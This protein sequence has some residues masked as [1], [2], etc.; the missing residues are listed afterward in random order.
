M[1]TK[2]EKRKQR[3]MTTSFFMSYRLFSVSPL[4]IVV[5]VAHFYL[6][7]FH[8]YLSVVLALWPHMNFSLSLVCV[9]FFF[10]SLLSPSLLSYCCRPFHCHI[11]LLFVEFIFSS[12]RIRFC[13]PRRSPEEKKS[14]NANYRMESYNERHL[15]CL[16]ETSQHTR[17]V[18]VKK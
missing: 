18:D 9:C 16:N 6:K 14:L 15:I 1:E 5:V 8:I 11:L 7:Y 2:R 12:S 10:Y 13:W 4:F 17:V 3:K